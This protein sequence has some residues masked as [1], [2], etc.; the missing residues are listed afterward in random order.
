M[1]AEQVELVAGEQA[2]R[3][4]QF[5]KLVEIQQE[6]ECAIAKMMLPRAEPS[7]HDGPGVNRRPPGHTGSSDMA[8]APASGGIAIRPDSLATRQGR[9]TPPNCSATAS[10]ARKPSS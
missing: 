6:P 7:M 4:R 5:R 2:G 9:R 8:A 3:S 1:Q 10:P